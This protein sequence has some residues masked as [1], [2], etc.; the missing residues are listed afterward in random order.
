[1]AEVLG[2]Q[3]NILSELDTVTCNF[4]A[5]I[6][7]LMNLIINAFYS[8]KEIF[9]RELISNASDALDKIRFKS[10]TDQSVLGN[11]SDLGISIRYNKDN[12][13]LTI[14]DN[15]IGMTREDL[16]NNLGTIASSGTKKFLEQL[17]EGS[18]DLK[19]IG[20]F[21]VGFYS[22]FLVADKVIVYSKNNDN[23]N[24]Y[25]WESNGGSNYILSV[26]NNS[27]VRGTSI[28]LH[29]KDTCTDLLNEEKLKDLVREHSS[30]ISYPIKLLVE[31]TREVEVEEEEV[32]ED[33]EDSEVVVVEDDDEKEEQ[34]KKTQTETYTEWDVLNT[35]RPIWLRNPAD[36]T[37]EEY[38]TFYQS[39]TNVSEE[40]SAKIHFA[41]EGKYVFRALLYI[42]K[43]APFDM[44]NKEDKKSNI[45]L[46]VRRVFITDK[47]SEII[48]E[49]FSFICGIVDSDDL[50]LNVSRELLQ[51][52]TY[53]KVIRKQ[54]VKKCVELLESLK[55]N[56]PEIYENVYHNYSKN[57]KLALHENSKYRE[58]LANLIKYQTTT[59]KQSYRYLS[60]YVENMKEEQ[61]AI[62][63]ISGENINVLVHSPFLE[64]LKQKNYEVLYLVEPIDEYVVQQLRTYQDKP[65]LCATKANLKLDENEEETKTFE[66]LTSKY[67]E[68]CNH[69]KEVLKNEVENVVVSNRIVESPLCLVTGEY[70][71]SANMERIM[72]AQALHNNYMNSYMMSKKIMEINPHHKIITMLYDR[73]NKDNN[74]E[75]VKHLIWILYDESLLVSGFSLKNPK[76]FAM[77]LNQILELGLE[78]NEDLE[79][80][81]NEDND[82]SE[83]LLE[84]E[85]EMENVD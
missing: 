10:L 9:L 51:H 78:T 72:K 37:E 52:S 6:Q 15:G 21:G 42:P 74:D 41:V 14:T 30:F 71:W 17:K 55:N 57:I 84:E 7:Q 45:K 23:D 64:R 38:K 82:K 53:M 56:E 75:T 65:L 76:H 61:P 43:R 66:E 3:G 20:Q 39:I 50:P 8:K 47:C 34:N 31:K 27:L 54:L 67:T 18:A 26:S 59:S 25:T 40:Y 16:I 46:Y 83:E 13:V 29:L 77:R 85:Q 32:E 19:M 35:Q 12:N 5:D 62:Y 11:S 22:S 2:D 48:P 28:E 1:M 69:I 36:I 79:N 80:E 4:D 73:Y 33:K 24:T 68:L 63:Y 70:G 58:R 49:F 81:D 60:E 44:F